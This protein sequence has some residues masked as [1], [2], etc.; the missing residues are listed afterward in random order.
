[1]VMR[2]GLGVTAAVTPS[3][4]Q[5]AALKHAGPLGFGDPSTYTADEQGPGWLIVEGNARFGG[6]SPRRRRAA[7]AASVTLGG[8]ARITPIG[9]CAP[10]RAPDQM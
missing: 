5:T 3:V 9:R 4:I 6:A 1:M 7:A 2:P 10:V 8:A